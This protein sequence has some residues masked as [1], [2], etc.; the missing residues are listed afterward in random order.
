MGFI[1]SVAVILAVTKGPVYRLRFERGPI[2]GDFLDDRWTQTA[3]C[4]VY[5]GAL[6]VLPREWSCR[7]GSTRCAGD[8]EPR[9]SAARRNAVVA[10][11]RTAFAQALMMALGT[12]AAIAIGAALRPITL[13]W[14]VWT[15]MMIGLG[16]SLVA[17]HFDWVLARDLEGH[18]VGIYFN[19]NSFGPVAVTAGLAGLGLIGGALDNE[20]S[21]R[22]RGSADGRIVTL[23]VA[24]ALGVHAGSLTPMVGL[25][26]ALIGSFVVLILVDRGDHT[27]YRMSSLP[28]A[29]AVR[30]G[31]CSGPWPSSSQSRRPP[32]VCTGQVRYPR[33]LTVSR[34]GPRLPGSSDDGRSEVGA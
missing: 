1:A 11:S 27:R 26:V 31:S 6:L 28:N 34:S 5:L 10:P 20:L 7:S 9:R 24:A 16:W 33:W 29:R 12:L 30:R 13:I 2:V 21:G 14:S 17:G 19:K 3:F 15:A 18:L 8:A 23:P 25:G 4:G 22:T 32:L